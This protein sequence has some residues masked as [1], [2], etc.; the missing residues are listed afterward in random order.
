MKTRGKLVDIS[1]INVSELECWIHE[2]SDRTL[3]LLSL[4]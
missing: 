4:V 2:S 3:L 1:A